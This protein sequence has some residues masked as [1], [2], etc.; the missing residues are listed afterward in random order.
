MLETT[1]AAGSEF[2]DEAAF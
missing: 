1:M 2:K